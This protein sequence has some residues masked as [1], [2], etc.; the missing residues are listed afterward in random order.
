[1]ANAT[2]VPMYVM[3]NA[4]PFFENGKKEDT[5]HYRLVSL[6]SISGKE[7]EKILLK[8]I[9]KVLKDKK[10]SKSSQYGFTNGEIML[11]R[12]DSLLP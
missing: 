12:P 2:C 7:M 1:M 10:M 8:T 5:G 4:V 11:N 9:S 3:A 6:T